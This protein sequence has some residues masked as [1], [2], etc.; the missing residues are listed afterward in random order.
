MH[1]GVDKP[2]SIADHM[3]R[4]AALALVL[5]GSS[6][7]SNKCVKLCIVHDMAEAIVGDIA[8]CDNVSDESKHS[9]EAAA[10]STIKGLLG[11]ETPAAREIEALWYAHSQGCSV[12]MLQVIGSRRADLG[13]V[14]G[15]L[16]LWRVSVCCHS[17]GMGCVALSRSPLQC[18]VLACTN[19]TERLMLV[20]VAC[21][22]E[23]EKCSSKEA[24]LVKD[25]D[26]L[27]RA[28]HC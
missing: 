22:W 15:S 10:I 18:L 26:K 20:C 7:D 25:F 23:Y 9:Q 27:V 21:R 28:C 19:C 2:E 6:Y 14:T 16:Q 5:E 13:V 24:Q 17:G 3:Y 1:H 11:E 4:M 12:R 8:P